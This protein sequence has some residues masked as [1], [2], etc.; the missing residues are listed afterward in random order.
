MTSEHERIAREFIALHGL[1]RH[2]YNSTLATLIAQA[3]ARGM[4]R[5]AMSAL[6]AKLPDGYLWGRDAMEQFR[7]GKAR[8]AEA[9][10]T[11]AAKM[12]VVHSAAQG[13]RDGG[14]LQ[15]I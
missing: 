4:E 2:I 5:A 6:N 12:P 3:E 9:I 11:E 7:F 1:S 13:R 8:A 15:R 10:R 14:L